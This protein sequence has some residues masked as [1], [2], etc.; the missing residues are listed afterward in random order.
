MV[1]GIFGRIAGAVSG[2]F[3]ALGAG[4]A[5][6]QAADKNSYGGLPNAAALVNTGCGAQS[7]WSM[8]WNLDPCRL[9]LGVRFA[10]AVK[11][12]TSALFLHPGRASFLDTYTIG[13]DASYTLKRF[14]QVLF[15]PA[16]D[17]MLGVN[18]HFGN[19][20]HTRVFLI[21]MLNFTPYAG[22]AVAFTLGAGVGP[23]LKTGS[24]AYE[25]LIHTRP[26]P[27]GKAHTGSRFLFEIYAKAGME[28]PKLLP[29]ITFSV[30]LD[31]TSC[32]G[33]LGLGL[34][35]NVRGAENNVTFG[36]DGTLDAWARR[37][38]AGAGAL[39]LARP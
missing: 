16:I 27:D 25:R 9:R 26:G 21:P 38:R 32:G 31:H 8:P 1:S 33:G 10:R 2:A 29:G 3:L 30:A 7:G 4:L 20:G 28:F 14:E 5:G 18:Q 24:S 23:S 6:A 12:Q 15:K 39:G 37:V 13:A 34:C 17:V 36:V 22:D 35:N 19:D 11:G